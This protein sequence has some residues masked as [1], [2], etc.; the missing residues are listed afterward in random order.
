MS[1]KAPPSQCRPGAE[2][3]HSCW[4][5]QH[6]GAAP[7]VEELDDVGEVHVV[8]ADDLAVGLHQGQ[9]DEQDKVLRRDVP[10]RPDHLPHSKHVLVGQLWEQQGAEAGPACPWGSGGSLPL[11]QSS[12][13]QSPRI[14]CTT[15][16][17]EQFWANP[18]PW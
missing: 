6:S 14:L 15:G 1:L 9:G 2:V 4:G 17:R 8:V 18:P 3:P 11:G 5:S 10:G 7:T 16:P 13:G 12:R